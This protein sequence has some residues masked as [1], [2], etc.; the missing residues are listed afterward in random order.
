MEKMKRQKEE[1]R[2]ALERK[3]TQAKQRQDRE[4]DDYSESESPPRGVTF[5]PDTHG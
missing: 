5:S 4:E 3:M 1:E 2:I